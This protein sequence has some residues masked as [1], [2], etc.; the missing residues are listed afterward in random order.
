MKEP[1]KTSPLLAHENLEFLSSPQARQVRILSEFLSPD[2]NFEKSQIKHTMVLFGS[3]RILPQDELDAK[4]AALNPNDPHDEI[5]RKRLNKLAHMCK[6]YDASRELGRRL[7]VWGKSR[8]ERYAVCTGGG[9]GIMEGGNRGAFDANSPSIGL[10]IQ[11]PYEQHP[12]PYIDPDLNFQF[13]YFFIRKFWFL[14]KARCLVAFPGGWG[15]FDELFETLTLM[16]THKIPRIPVLVFG[17]SYWKKLV[18]WEYFIETAMID[19]DDMNYI[20]FTDS[21]DEGYVWLAEQME[22][23]AKDYEGRGEVLAGTFH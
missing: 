1:L 2:T 21:V 20:K 6:Y 12:N 13:H 11:L 17:E 9:P 16:Q 22:K 23:N 4:L 10:N 7:S 5:K 19:D 14:F 8:P 18:N 15:T 3:A